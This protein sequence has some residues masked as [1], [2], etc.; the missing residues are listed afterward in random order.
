MSTSLLYYKKYGFRGF[1]GISLCAPSGQM[2][3]VQSFFGPQLLEVVLLVLVCVCVCVCLPLLAVLVAKNNL[4][5]RACGCRGG[6][7]KSYCLGAAQGTNANFHNCVVR[8]LKKV[9]IS[10]ICL[11]PGR[12]HYISANSSQVSKI[13]KCSR[14]WACVNLPK[15]SFFWLGLVGVCSG[16][17]CSYFLLSIFMMDGGEACTRTTKSNEKYEYN[18]TI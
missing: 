10:K 5:N 18:N 1:G 6:A 11:E 16:G 2:L 14:F 9:D 4:Q 15:L 8:I 7:L 3:C 17:W 12:K 13:F